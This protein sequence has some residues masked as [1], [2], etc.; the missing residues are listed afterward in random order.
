MAQEMVKISFS[1]WRTI[2]AEL[3]KNDPVGFIRNAESSGI[4][5]EAIGRIIFAPAGESGL[6]EEEFDHIMREK[7]P[8]HEVQEGGI[9]LTQSDE[10]DNCECGCEN[11]PECQCEDCEDHGSD[12][13]SKGRELIHDLLDKI[14]D[15]K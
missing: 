4:T 12:N 11:G 8:F 5:K 15:V 1:D 7:D 3:Y 9:E 14:M 13:K 10:A 2:G 6:H